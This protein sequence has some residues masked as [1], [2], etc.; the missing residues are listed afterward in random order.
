MGSRAGRAGIS[1]GWWV[2][3]GRLLVMDVIEVVIKKCW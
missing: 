1:V 3:S 2:G